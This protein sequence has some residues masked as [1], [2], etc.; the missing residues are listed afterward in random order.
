MNIAVLVKLVPDTEASL[1][2]GGDHKYIDTADINFVLNPYD[3][4][5]VEE[6]L[7][8]KEK[9]G[10]SVTV[11]SLGGNEAVKALRNSLAMGAD[12][13]IHVKTQG[14]HDLLGTAKALANVLKE[15]DFNLIFAG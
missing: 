3:E 9:H 7:K 12:Q 5:A 1:K 15:R 6:A 8:Q 11:I 4:Y 10:G 13:A 2:I 14:G